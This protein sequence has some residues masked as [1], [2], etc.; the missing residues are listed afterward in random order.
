MRQN[1]A[2][3]SSVRKQPETF[4]WTDDSSEDLSPPDYCQKEPQ[5]RAGTA[6]RP[7]FAG[8][9]D[10]AD[11]EQGFVWVA[12]GFASWE[13]GEGD[14][15][16]SLLSGSHHSDEGSLPAPADPVRA[17]PVLWLAR[18]RLSS[19]AADLSSCV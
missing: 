15:L 12:L 8:R 18:P 19:R 7:T 4:C 1:I 9:V 5:N 16:G 3:P 10:Q 2:T 14:W 17:G 11:C 13:V 6:A